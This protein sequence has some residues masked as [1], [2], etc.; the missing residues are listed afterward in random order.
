M[1]YL[2]INI[3]FSSNIWITKLMKFIYILELFHQTIWI[4][5][6][7]IDSSNSCIIWYKNWKVT[8][9][10]YL[11]HTYNIIVTFT[12]FKDDYKF[13]AHNGFRV[14]INLSFPSKFYL[15]I[16]QTALLL[17][18][19]IITQIIISILNYIF[20]RFYYLCNLI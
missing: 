9:S 20:I 11:M 14:I 8:H 2:H 7:E 19:I 4:W 12:L 6:M 16:S 1:W 3:S 13:F 17:C 5:E 15:F 10:T 18:D